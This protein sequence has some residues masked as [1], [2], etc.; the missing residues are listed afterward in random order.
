MTNRVGVII[1]CAVCGD[2]KKP[3]GRAGPL[4]ASYCDLDCPGYTQKP[5]VGSLWPG[6]TSEEF[7][8]PIGINGTV[9]VAHSLPQQE[10]E[11][12]GKR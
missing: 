4:G 3:I 5:Y 12:D 11:K 10:Q 1:R 8:Y 7:G 2:M 9:E 6:E